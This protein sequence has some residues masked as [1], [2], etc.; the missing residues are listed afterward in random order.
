MP[1][2]LTPEDVELILMNEDWIRYIS[3]DFYVTDEK[4]TAQVGHNLRRP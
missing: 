2:D 4:G 1:R 3:W